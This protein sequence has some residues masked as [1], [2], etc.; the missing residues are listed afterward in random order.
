MKVVRKWNWD[1]MYKICNKYNL[2]TMMN[3][4]EYNYLCD[5]ISN[6][7]PTDAKIEKVARMVTDKSEDCTYNAILNVL[8]NEVIHYTA[9]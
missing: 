9:V 6:N 3:S 5:Y 1:D 7:R 2:C 4:A 8:L